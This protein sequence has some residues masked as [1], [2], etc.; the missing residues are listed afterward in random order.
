MPIVVGA[1]VPPPPRPP[2]APIVIQPDTITAEWI[3]PYG[4]VLPLS[5]PKRNWFTTKGIGGW[6]A[7][8]VSR[9]DDPSARGGV[10]T[11][12]VRDEPRSITWP[13]HV[14][15]NTSDEF[16]ARMREVVWAFTQTKMYGPG[17]LRVS[18]PDGSAREISAYYEDGL[19]GD[20]GQGWLSANPVLTLFCPN[21]FWQATTTTTVTR[22]YGVSVPFLAPYPTVS[23]SQV[24]GNTQI[25]NPGD[26]DAWPT[27]L[28]TG[29]A[30]S[31]EATSSTTGES[32]EITYALD[33]GDTIAIT[34]DPPTVRGPAGQPL[35]SALTWP[36]AELWPLKP[37]INNINFEVAG[38][39]AGTS[40]TLSWKPRY[41]MW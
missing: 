34:T 27:W 22:S 37:R 32:F 20:V 19:G 11:R 35:T 16:V 4:T 3:A 9:V 2:R 15:G 36:G 23:S 14:W 39:G 21:G 24:L 6:G 25:T 38:A 31:I 29:P 40:I 13:L 28:I 18:R 33:A 26:A 7:V 30:S 41:E 8:P 17:V 10:V 12:H 1:Q 5:R